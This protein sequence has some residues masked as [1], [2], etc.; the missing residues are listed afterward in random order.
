MIAQNGNSGNGHHPAARFARRAKKGRLN[1]VGISSGYHDSACALL[2]DGVLVAAVQEERFSRVKNDKSFP[3]Q[4][5][6]YCLRR[7]ESRSPTSIALATTK[8][9]A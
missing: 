5:F 9:R 6:A 4:A 2:Q 3:I 8:I 7:P 1:V